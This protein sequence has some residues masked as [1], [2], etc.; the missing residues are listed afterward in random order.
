[1]ARL[2]KAM[3]TKRRIPAPHEGRK[4]TAVASKCTWAVAR[5]SGRQTDVTLSAE[6]STL[7]LLG[8]AQS[9]TIPS[10]TGCFVHQGTGLDWTQ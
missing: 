3:S 8:R 1:M 4:V 7:I 6:F 10:T 2:R 5:V 9:S